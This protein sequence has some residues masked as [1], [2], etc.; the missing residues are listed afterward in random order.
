[1][2]DRDPW[3]ITPVA[4]T[5]AA[6]ND[7]WEPPAPAPAPAS[8]PPP[9]TFDALAPAIGPLGLV[10][11]G[12]LVHLGKRLLPQ[13]WHDYITGV[14]R[15][16][17]QGATMNFGDEALAAI[18]SATGQGGYDDLLARERKSGK[19]FAQE[20]PVGAMAGE[21]SGALTGA[22]AVPLGPLGRTSIQAAAKGAPL[23]E[24]AG[25]M[26]ARVLERALKGAGVGAAFG[27]GSGYGEGEGGV[28]ERLAAAT[29]G[30]KTGAMFGAGL[31]VGLPAAA[32]GA[33]MLMDAGRGAAR[34]LT[35]PQTQGA[36]QAAAGEIVEKLGG[37]SGK[38]LLADLAT[39]QSTAPKIADL[40]IPTANLM[41]NAGLQAA[42]RAELRRDPASAVALREGREQGARNTLDPMRPDGAPIAARVEIEGQDAARK[43]ALEAAEAQRVAA[44][45]EAQDAAGAAR[46]EA[47]EGVRGS[48]EDARGVGQAAVEDARMA[49]AQRL[50]EL[51]RTLEDTI[52]GLKARG[53]SE[54]DAAHMA[55]TDAL[56]AT[57]AFPGK[58]AASRAALE[59]INAELA[60]NK[61][62]GKG[63]YREVPPGTRLDVNPIYDT[64][65]AVH[66][67]AYET[68]RTTLIPSLVKSE[69]LLDLFRNPTPQRLQG[70]KSML[71]EEA[72]RLGRSGDLTSAKWA[73]DVARSIDDVLSGAAGVADSGV[74]E[75]RAA[76]NWWRERVVPYR[77]GVI[78]DI[79]KVGPDGLPRIEPT[80][81][82]GKVIKPSRAGGTEA[83]DEFIQAAGGRD[84]ALIAATEWAIADAAEYAI[85]SNGRVNL[86]RLNKWMRERGPVLDALPG[87][88]ERLGTTQ[89]LA[90]RAE[91]AAVQQSAAVQRAKD[92]A[93]E[94]IRQAKEAVDAQ[95]KAAQGR[96]A[97]AVKDVAA[98]GREMMRQVEQRATEQ[99]RA[100]RD[101]Q[102][103]N[104]EGARRSVDEIQK[105]AAKL[106]LGTDPMAAAQ[107][108]MNSA[109]PA[110]AYMQVASRLQGNAEAQ[111]GLKRAL[112]D[113]LETEL[114]SFATVETAVRQG[115][116]DLI[117]ANQ[118]LLRA[119]FGPDRAAQATELLRA[120][121]KSKAHQHIPGNV[122]S[123]TAPHLDQGA[124]ADA[125]V[126]AIVG[127]ASHIPLV[128]HLLNMAR[129]SSREAVKGLIKEALFDPEKMRVLLETRITRQNAPA[130]AKRL[131]EWMERRTM[132]GI[133]VRAMGDATTQERER[134]AGRALGGRIGMDMGGDP[135]GAADRFGALLRGLRAGTTTPQGA[136]GPVPSLDPGSPYPIYYRPPG[137]GAG[138][139]SGV[140]APIAGGG[141]TAGL[142]GSSG[143][144]PAPFYDIGSGAVA[145][146]SG[147]PTGA[148][149]VGP[150]GEGLAADAN[151]QSNTSNDNIHNPVS[152]MANQIASVV[153]GLVSP[154][155]I[156][157]AVM[158]LGR[159]AAGQTATAM[160]AQQTKDSSSGT[161]GVGNT[162]G[163]TANDANQGV[164][165][166]G[167][168]ASTAG[169]AGTTGEGGGT[170]P[171]SSADAAS[172]S[173]GSSAG[174]STGDSGAWARGGYIDVARRYGRRARRDSGGTVG[175]D[176]LARVADLIS[177]R[178]AP[179]ESPFYRRMMA[180]PM[181]QN[182]EDI[183]HLGPMPDETLLPLTRAEVDAEMW[184]INGED[185]RARLQRAG[186]T[187]MPESD[188]YSEIA[189][190]LSGRR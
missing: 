153:M 99:V 138:T 185:E 121:E 15:A 51:E 120:L 82:L 182:V 50:R 179:A 96:G 7:P 67:E 22:A 45:R 107:G 122:G 124:V 164:S 169:P 90:L 32:A 146:P 139:G 60:A 18:G 95:V 79:L 10:T 1:M 131:T 150:T 46:F 19:D 130:I 56:M 70:M 118:P 170:G 88:R 117:T 81:A 106:F 162:S 149:S 175:G 21:L 20:N 24:K 84:N 92:D 127:R 76:A 73:R 80:T 85:G 135:V 16:A 42:T 154:S 86:A 4:A 58:A 166:P 38:D 123:P 71:Y 142:I 59:A 68:G 52:E 55:A 87:L 17:F 158:S 190:I 74:P 34:A 172:A 119:V 105:S 136:Y 181:S 9:S 12:P 147:S 167:E 177:R 156:M 168:A 104:V 151:A 152:Q 111:A 109:D 112:F 63:L 39:G 47:R 27:F 57:G 77:Q 161:A 115:T 137:Y 43:A 28:D 54:T 160:S 129:D 173:P 23:I 31:N 91:D 174:D 72:S 53:M 144:L 93:A 171:G 159:Q 110:R 148:G 2:A 30:A 101:A 145:S 36:Q 66:R 165:D 178:Y 108:I 25:R 189:A 114:S 35:G 143:V 40:P 183:R 61:R 94:A 163:V 37:K 97:E 188:M 3:E 75:L 126:A 102:A 49:G 187:A 141:T 184:R 6:R 186:P 100:A 65:G 78:G 98:R 176:L 13:D 62:I 29:S 155:P 113:A 133:P 83:I 14:Q 33:G 128:G 180:A 26:G 44:V 41:D 125:A 132:E 69:T 5:T 64:L 157:S 48:L 116:R 11:G 8:T 134:R 140:A 89:A 103:A